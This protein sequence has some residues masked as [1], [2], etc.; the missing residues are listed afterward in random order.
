MAETQD[1]QEIIDVVAGTSR[2]ERATLTRAFHDLEIAET[3]AQQPGPHTDAELEEILA[4]VAKMG[5]QSR[6]QL[7]EQVRT[8]GDSD[9]THFVDLLL[10]YGKLANA[11]GESTP[12]DRTREHVWES[13]PLAPDGEDLFLTFTD[14]LMEAVYDLGGEPYLIPKDDTDSPVGRTLKATICVSLVLVPFLLERAQDIRKLR[15]AWITEIY[16]EALEHARARSDEWMPGE[17]ER[18]GF[19]H[20]DSRY[21][22]AA[23]V[24]S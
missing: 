7:A 1:L 13:I 12:K 23:A 6:G 2:E 16:N 5:S 11:Q 15:P 19:V 18:E 24:G 8:L 3:E 14:M 10:H 17:I 4:T 22:C 21:T 20:Y 9:L